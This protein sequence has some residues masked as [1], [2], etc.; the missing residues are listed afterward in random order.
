[1][2]AL[3]AITARLPLADREQVIDEALAAARQVTDK[4]GRQRRGLAL[5]QVARHLPAERRTDLLWE[6]FI[7][8]R[9]IGDQDRLIGL[10][11]AIGSRLPDPE[12]GQVLRQAAAAAQAAS[13]PRDRV[14]RLEDVA[15]WA[16]VRLKAELLAQALDIVASDVREYYSRLVRLARDIPAELAERAF[17]IAAPLA[18]NPQWVVFYCRV[19]INLA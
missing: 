2:D 16:P 19:L 7:A 13:E 17:D 15:T 18:D 3:L 5:S 4:D 12:G 14:S 8:C 10:R 1:C 9:R 11:A 6:A